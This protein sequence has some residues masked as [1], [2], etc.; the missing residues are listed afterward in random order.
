MPTID[1]TLD[2][3]PP[4]ATGTEG[5]PAS[6]SAPS[7]GDPQSKFEGERTT[8]PPA[9]ADPGVMPPILPPT[10][11]PADDPIDITQA[12]IGHN[13]GD[14]AAVKKL[15]TDVAVGKPDKEHFIRV[16][17]EVDHRLNCHL[18]RIK[19]GDKA[20][21]Y[22]WLARGIA[23][24]LAALTSVAKLIAAYTLFTGITRAGGLFLW[25][26]PL[27]DENGEM[28]SW[29]RSAQEAATI[30][31]DQWIRVEANMS[32]SNYDVWGA[33]GQVPDPQW[34]DKSLQ[35]LIRLGFKQ[36]LIDRLDHPVLL[37]LR[38]LE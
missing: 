9:A 22:Y 13:F 1:D 17:P 38:G 28:I 29:Y 33:E 6:T 21:G 18:L 37:Q 31:Q 10:P 30:A 24:Q 7:P 25:P 2:P 26:I 15:V 3:I 19:Q 34:P 20:K 27:P 4:S 11:V 5:G 8:P 14:R 35:E 12:R 32:R 16:R 36:K 23:D